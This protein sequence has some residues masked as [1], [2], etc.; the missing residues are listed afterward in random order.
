MRLM[1]LSLSERDIA[2][3]CLNFLSAS[4]FFEGGDFETR[5]GMTRAELAT[6]MSKWPHLNDN[7]SD[8]L[9]WTAINNAFNEVC[10]GIRFTHEE[11]QYWF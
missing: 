6:V 11:W 4:N 2:L 9:D 1:D 8:H 3:Q 5:L 7:E 10:N